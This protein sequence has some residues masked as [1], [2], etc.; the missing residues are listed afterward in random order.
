LDNQSV[1]SQNAGLRWN[2]RT[3]IEVTIPE[4]QKLPGLLLIEAVCITLSSVILAISVII[5]IL[6]MGFQRS[7]IAS[8]IVAGLA[9][10]TLLGVTVIADLKITKLSKIA[11]SIFNQ[12]IVHETGM[13]PIDL[14]TIS[15]KKCGYVHLS[16][17]HNVFMWEIFYYSDRPEVVSMEKFSAKAYNKYLEDGTIR[18]A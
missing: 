10:V 16:D 1:L 8:I 11:D 18:V 3:S 15:Q 17:G 5:F 2:G 12:A 9:L 14:T 6:S 4:L 7:D 13:K